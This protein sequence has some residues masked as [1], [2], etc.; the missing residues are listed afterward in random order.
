MSGCWLT[1]QQYY[2]TWKVTIIKMMIFLYFMYNKR[3]VRDQ[4]SVYL[5]TKGGMSPVWHGFA[6]VSYIQVNW[7]GTRTSGRQELLSERRVTFTLVWCFIWI[8]IYS[9][10]ID[11][12][13]LN[14]T[15]FLLTSLTGENLSNQTGVF[16]FKDLSANQTPWRISKVHK[17]H[18]FCI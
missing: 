4:S 11:P 7:K 16:K 12:K 10:R 5:N 1:I 15:F 3:I 2:F 6:S 14:W 9:Y 17:Y 18:L 13:S 8:L